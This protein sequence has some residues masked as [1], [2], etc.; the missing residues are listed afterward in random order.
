MLVNR[1][2]LVA[3]LKRIHCDGMIGDVVLAESLEVAALTVPKDMLVIAPPLEGIQPL[4]RMIG[5]MDLGRLITALEKLVEGETEVAIGFDPSRPRLQLYTPD[6]TVHFLTTRPVL[7]GTMVYPANV[8]RIQ[9]WTNGK[10]AAALPRS[11]VEFVLASTPILRA[12]TVTFEVSPTGTRVVIGH[13]LYDYAECLFEHLTDET[14]YDLILRTHLLIA[15]LKQIGDWTQS[16]FVVCGP[17][18]V[19]AIR[20]AGYE[21]I[22]ATEA[23]VTSWKGGEEANHEDETEPELAGLLPP[24]PATRGRIG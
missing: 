7:I 20:C 19:V 2:S 13:E 9:A 14:R 18:S 1:N 23:P 22:L 16:E 15:V 17:D 24:A 5:V 4:P 3:H 6:G 10:S 12:E 21:Y 11:V 8:E